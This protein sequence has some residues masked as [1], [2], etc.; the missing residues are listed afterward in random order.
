MEFKNKKLQAHDW[1]IVVFGISLQFYRMAFYD[2]KLL[3]NSVQS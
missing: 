3:F 1:Q 2:L